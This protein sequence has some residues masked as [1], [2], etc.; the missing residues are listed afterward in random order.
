[1]EIGNRNVQHVN[2]AAKLQIENAVFVGAERT[3][4]EIERIMP[5]R[6]RE[7]RCEGILLAGR[8]PSTNP[9]VEAG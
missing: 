8:L 4:G 5:E 9:T 3:D 1:M 7:L 6:P 2:S